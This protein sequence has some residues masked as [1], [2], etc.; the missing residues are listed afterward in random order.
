MLGDPISW[1]WRTMPTARTKRAWRALMR[2]A[3]RGEIDALAKVSRLLRRH[4]TAASRNVATP[5]R[6]QGWIRPRELRL[7]PLTV[8][9]S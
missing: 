3:A 4:G 5:S 7:G 6:P 8:M 2:S 9:L 1:K